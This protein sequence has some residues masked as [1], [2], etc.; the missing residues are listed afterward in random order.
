MG[1]VSGGVLLIISWAVIRSGM[2]RNGVLQLL[3]F[4]PGTSFLSWS[5]WYFAPTF[6]I[7]TRMDGVDKMERSGLWI[8]TISYSLFL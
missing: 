3:C 1:I 4:G 5:R 7:D 6:M 8:F 2:M